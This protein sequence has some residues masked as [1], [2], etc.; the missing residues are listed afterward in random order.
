MADST[1]KKPDFN[2]FDKTKKVTNATG[3]KKAVLEQAGVKPH[4]QG[5]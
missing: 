2:P 5:R 3:L 4:P 1:T